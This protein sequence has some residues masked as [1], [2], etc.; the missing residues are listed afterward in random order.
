MNQRRVKQMSP[1]GKQICAAIS[2]ALAWLE[3]LLFVARG[4]SLGA[5]PTTPFSH[6]YSVHERLAFIPPPT[7]S[8]CSRLN[9]AS[10]QSS[11]L[12]SGI[13][14]QEDLS[15]QLGLYLA[16]PSLGFQRLLSA[17]WET[18]ASGFNR[19]TAAQS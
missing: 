9:S 6:T 5:E 15:H 17:R 13:Q 14:I 2:A 11:H 12:P 8:D 10:L 19:T 7:P 4:G 3:L 1:V 16:E 18:I